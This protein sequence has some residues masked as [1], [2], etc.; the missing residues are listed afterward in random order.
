MI[1]LF[2]EAINGLFT[3]YYILILIRCAMSFI[4][5]IDWRKQPSSFIRQVT[6]PYLD[7]FRKLI[8][9]IGMIDIS[10]IVALIVLGVIQNVILIL[11]SFVI[12]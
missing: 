12:G 9:P 1:R 5:N 2:I 3:L 8:P 11:I 10:P 6:D 7:I 4:P